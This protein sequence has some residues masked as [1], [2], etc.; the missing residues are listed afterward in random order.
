MAASL[1]ALAAF[2]NTAPGSPPIGSILD[3]AAFLWTE[4]IIATWVPEAKGAAST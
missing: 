4:A 2:R 1:F 3:Y